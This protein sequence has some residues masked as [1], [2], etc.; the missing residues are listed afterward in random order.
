MNTK[1]ETNFWVF[2]EHTNHN[3]PMIFG[4]A[5][6]AEMD[7]AAALCVKRF[8]YDSKTCEDAVT[9]KFDGEFLAPCYVGDLIYLYARVESAGKKSVVVKVTASRERTNTTLEM[10]AVA[11]FVFVTLE[12]GKVK[13]EDGKLPYKEHGLKV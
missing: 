3:F 9:Y 4:G 13:S 10:V 1:F 7:K 12:A 6:F 2:P 11:N 8:L 5:F